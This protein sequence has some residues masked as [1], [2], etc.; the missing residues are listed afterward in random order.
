MLEIIA[1]LLFL[2]TFA[3]LCTDV[4]RIWNFNLKNPLL[5]IIIGLIMMV[6]GMISFIC[7]IKRFIVQ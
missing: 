6:F 2:I 4:K 5:R 3:L 7:D 1:N